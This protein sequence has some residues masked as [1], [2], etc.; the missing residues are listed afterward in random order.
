M[1]KAIQE[2]RT[3]QQDASFILDSAFTF[4]ELARLDQFTPSSMCSVKILW[5]GKW[6]TAIVPTSALIC[7]VATLRRKRER[8]R[9]SVGMGAN[10]R[11]PTIGTQGAKIEVMAV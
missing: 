9:R 1:G 3:K 6:L 2:P 4:I 5:Q 8:F 7:A 11:H 10:H